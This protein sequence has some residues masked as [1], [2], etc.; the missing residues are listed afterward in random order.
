MELVREKKDSNYFV[1]TEVIKNENLSNNA[2]LL[3][4]VL[5][6]YPDDE[7]F[8]MRQLCFK[9]KLTELEIIKCI[10][11]LSSERYMVNFGAKFNT[12]ILFNKRIKSD[13]DNKLINTYREKRDLGIRSTNELIKLISNNKNIDKFF[14]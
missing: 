5:S 4:I 13:A 6:N 3:H 2:K 9:L 7:N 8:S 12:Y 11:E 10:G 14:E 1:S